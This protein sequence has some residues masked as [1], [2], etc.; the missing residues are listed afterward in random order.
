MHEIPANAYERIVVRK[1]WT[2]TST[3]AR[4]RWGWHSWRRVQKAGQQWRP[5]HSLRPCERR[6]Q[7]ARTT[8]YIYMSK[9]AQVF[10]MTVCRRDGKYENRPPFHFQAGTYWCL[11]GLF[12]SHLLCGTVGRRSSPSL[13]NSLWRY[14]GA[15]LGRCGCQ[16][17]R[18]AQSRGPSL[19]DNPAAWLG[20]KRTDPPRIP[21]RSRNRGGAARRGNLGSK[22]VVALCR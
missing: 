14:F 16:C 6:P 5:R 19:R 13:S 20:A 3:V 21:V 7:T 22:S 12:V 8:P 2:H 10:H 17:G 11:K 15:A 4:K 18:E 1:R 9:C